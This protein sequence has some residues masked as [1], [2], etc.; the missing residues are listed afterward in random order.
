MTGEPDRR[1]L[2]RVVSPGA[3]RLTSTVDLL[4]AGGGAG[5]TVTESV[6]VQSPA[7]LRR[8]ALRQARSVQRSRAAELTR[9]MAAG[10]AG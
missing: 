7:P 4:S 9:R 10:N 6:E 2:S 3:V 5:T 8:F 1:V